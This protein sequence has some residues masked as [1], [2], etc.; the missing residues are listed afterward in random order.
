MLLLIVRLNPFTH[1][2]CW[3]KMQ[4]VLQTIIQPILAWRG[5]FFFGEF[6][7]N[8]KQTVNGYCVF[9]SKKNIIPTEWQNRFTCI[10]KSIQK[11]DLW[12]CFYFIL[13]T[14]F[15]ID[16]YIFYSCN[17]RSIVT[18][19]GANFSVICPLKSQ[20]FIDILLPLDFL[21]NQDHIRMLAIF[22]FDTYAIWWEYTRPTCFSHNE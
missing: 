22:P 1:L 11:F 14:H 18:G 6:W 13:L 4:A 3:N 15:E 16:F 2:F 10:V 8:Y 9:F 19:V 20:I 12:I 21:H 7:K 17:F 5:Q